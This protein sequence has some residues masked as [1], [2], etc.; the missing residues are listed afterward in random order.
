MLGEGIFYLLDAFCLLGG[1]NN[2][3]ARQNWIANRYNLTAV[4][5]PTFTT[6]PR[7]AAELVG[8]ILYTYTGRSSGDIDAG[9]FTA[10]GFANRAV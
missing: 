6:H 4:N 8:H 9:S 7:T 2:T 5:S 1:D 10:L 3:F